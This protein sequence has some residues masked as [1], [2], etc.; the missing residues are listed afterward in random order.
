MGGISYD[1]LKA[2]E[3]Y[4]PGGYD[5][6][7]T[8]SAV[9][10]QAALVYTLT[11]TSKVRGSISQKSY[12][13]SMKDRY[14]GGLGTRV[15][16][17]DLDR[18]LTTHYELSYAYQ[19]QKYSLNANFYIS[20]VNDAIEGVATN[21]TYTKKGNTYSKEQ[22]QNVGDFRH[23]GFELDMAYQNDGTK[24]GGNYA[25]IDVENRNDNDVKRTGIPKNQVFA[26]AQQEVGAGF[27]LYAN[28]RFRDGVYEQNT[29]GD[30]VQLSSFTTFDA[31]IL[32]EAMKTVFIEVGVKN[33]TDELVEYDIGFPDAGREYFATLNY[34]F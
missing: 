26:Y 6:L 23:K 11:P 25:Y 10:P 16:N 9:N 34:K 30:Y 20:D 31:K 24:I 5:G 18:E 15:A 8:I 21:Q 12:L 2:D 17:P 1:Q 29:N 14:S 27:S 3:V 32:F 33:L 28:M 4:Y 22:N 7:D 19:V 13:P